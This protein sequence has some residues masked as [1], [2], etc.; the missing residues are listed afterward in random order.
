MEEWK[1]VPGHPAYKISSLERLVGEFGLVKP[2]THGRTTENACYAMEYKNTYRRM[3]IRDMM[4][5]VWD[6]ELTPTQEWIEWVI[7]TNK[8]DTS[9]VR[10]SKAHGRSTAKNITN[11]CICGKEYER[12]SFD[13]WCCS[14]DCKKVKNNRA[15][16]CDTKDPYDFKNFDKLS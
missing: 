15:T 16:T 5:I 11:C 7:V 1:E 9:F 2:Y 3:K 10:K 8:N 6:K 14:K 13:D 4:G 12:Y